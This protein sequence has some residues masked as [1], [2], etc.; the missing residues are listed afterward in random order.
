MIYERSANI[1][2]MD[3]QSFSNYQQKGKNFFRIFLRG[4]KTNFF[5]LL[6]GVKLTFV[7]IEKIKL[8]TLRLYKS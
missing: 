6:C 4:E 8:I 5:L 3:G 2:K 7:R 1:V